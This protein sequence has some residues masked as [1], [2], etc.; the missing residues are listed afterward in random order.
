[1]LRRSNKSNRLREDKIPLWVVVGVILGAIIVYIAMI[2][3][4]RGNETATPEIRSS[5]TE[6]VNL[7]PVNESGVVL[8]NASNPTR[9]DAP[10]GSSEAPERSGPLSE[11]MIPKNATRIL[12][13]RESFSPSR[14]KVGVGEVI[15]LALTSGDEFTHVLAFENSSLRAI[16]LGVSGK[17]TRAIRFNAPEE[18]GEYVFYQNMP[19]FQN[20]RGVMVV[21]K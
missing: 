8:A 21:E 18:E 20:V 13:T 5:N 7:S 3:D 4:E 9:N 15:I 14:I 1:M 17:E 2:K 19:G 11:D 12:A 6:S 10:P 16:A